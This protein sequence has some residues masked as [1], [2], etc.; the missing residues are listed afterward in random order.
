MNIFLT[1]ASGNLGVH[2]IERFSKYIKYELHTPIHKTNILKKYSNNKSIIKCRINI[3]DQAELKNYLINNDIDL[4]IHCAA[5]TNLDECE[6]NKEKSKKTNFLLTKKIVNTISNLNI[7]LVYIS[8][9]HLFGNNLNKKNYENSKKYAVNFY[10]KCKISSENYI[11][12]KLKNFLIIRTNFFGKSF[13]KNKMFIE[14]ILK[15][16]QN[17][18][19]FLFKDVYF[20]PIEVTT[21]TKLI[22]L[23]VIKGKK[24]IFHCSSDQKISKLHFGLIVFKIFKLNSSN[25]IPIKLSDNKGLIAKRAKNMFISNHKIKKLFP[26]VDLSIYYQI[27][28]Y[29]KNKNVLQ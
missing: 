22:Y 13:T 10:A 17:N 6:I 16:G 26:S 24:G 3:F 5:M 27:K 28:T 12:K 1:G 2:L 9:D 4:I 14:E 11:I 23:L 19:I 29:K 18:K 8:S 25:I 7:K 21:L 15:V 20:N